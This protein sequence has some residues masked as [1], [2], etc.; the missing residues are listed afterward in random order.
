MK[1]SEKAKALADDLDRVTAQDLPVAVRGLVAPFLPKITKPAQ[2]VAAL[3]VEVCER[4]E[5]LE[6]K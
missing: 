1:L 2:D 3:V 4:L 6:A 5:A